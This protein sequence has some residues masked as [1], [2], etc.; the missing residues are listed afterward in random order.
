MLLEFARGWFGEKLPLYHVKRFLSYRPTG[1]KNYLVDRYRTWVVHPIKRRVSKYYLLFLRTFCNLKV[2]GITGSAGK[3][4]TKD[5]VASILRQ[6]GE[7]IASNLNIDPVFN[8]PTT[9]LKCRPSTRYLVLEMGV[10][11]PGEMDFYLWLGKPDVGVITNIYP[12][13]TLFFKNVEGVARE[14]GKL[15]RNISQ[16]SFAILNKDNKFTPQIAKRIKARGVSF[17]NGGDF[18]AS[19]IKFVHNTSTK[20]V[21]LCPLG[22]ISI[23]IPILGE[24]FVENALAS[25]A[26]GYSLG[27]SLTKIKRGFAKLIPQDHRMRIF[28]LEKGT[29]VIDDSYNNNP[30]AAEKA[31][32]TF[33]KIYIFKK[34]ILI[35]GDMLELGTLEKAEHRKIGNLIG[36]LG[37][38]AAIFVGPASKLSSTKAAKTMGKK[39]VFWVNSSEMVMPLLR[40]LIDNKTTIFVK[41]SRGIALDKVVESILNEKKN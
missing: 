30:V 9:I 24:Q 33:G 4:T 7:T 34:K 21:L 13:H 14:K 39:N 3:T 8:I 28:T 10:E 36:K 17:G 2:V 12:T 29:I 1:I 25:S 19:E 41:G 23:Q 26:V 20:F 22:K 18:S 16:N 31:L 5:M 11:V 35:F 27:L 40:P 37:F 38:D 32:S 15:V 6:D